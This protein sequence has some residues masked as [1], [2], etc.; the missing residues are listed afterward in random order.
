MEILLDAMLDTLID[1]AKLVPFLFVAFLL[2]EYLEHK[3]SAK[4]KRSIAKAE[5]FGPIIGS[6]LG[7]VPQC[8]F[9]VLASNFYVGRI[10]SLGTLISIYLSTSD[11]TLPI[12]VGSNAPIGDILKIL[13]IKVAVGMVAGMIIDAVYHPKRKRNYEVCADEHRHHHEP[14]IK[15]SLIHT[16]KTAAYIAVITFV[17]DLLFDVVGQNAVSRLFLVGNIF[18]PLVSALIGLI[19]NCGASV[20][21]TEL[22][23]KNVISMGTCIGGLLTGAGVGLLILFRNNKDKAENVRIM[24]IIYLIGAIVGTTLNIVGLQ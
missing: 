15:S 14:I 19:P 16:L 24:L 18:A 22:Y 8:G 6:L 21:I 5:K 3:I 17:L 7:A 23:L 2:M 11:E 4:V 9:S 20:M 12:L 10:I 13:S 1:T